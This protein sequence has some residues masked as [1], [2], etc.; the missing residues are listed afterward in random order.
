MVQ[1]AKLIGGAGTGKTTELLRI[2]SEIVSRGVDPHDIG[3]VSFTQAARTEAAERVAGEFGVDAKRLQER[4]WFRTLHSVCY[5]G[6][7]GKFGDRM[8]TGTKADREWME[9]VL[10]EPCRGFGSVGPTEDAG[11]VYEEA[12]RPAQALMIW[13]LARNRMVSIADVR[14]ELAQCGEDVPSLE[15]CVG[16]AKMYEVA[17]YRDDRM[18]FTDLAGKFAG[19][20]WDP[21]DE[22]RAGTPQGVT[23]DV[24]V[25]IFDEHQDVSRLLDSVAARLAYSPGC[26]WVYYAGDPFQSIYGFGGSD[27]RCLIDAPC[28]QYRV[29]ERSW[30]CPEAILKLG[31]KILRPSADYFDRK[32]KPNEPGGEIRRVSS[33]REIVRHVDPNERWLMIARTNYHTTKIKAFLNR[34]G[35]PWDYTRGSGGYVT[36]SLRTVCGTLY[37]L[38]KGGDVDGATW[39]TVLKNLPA[40]RGEGAFLERG[41][42]TSVVA[43]KYTPPRGW[44]GLERVTEAGGTE[45]LRDLIGSGSWVHHVQ[46]ADGYVSAIRKW[47]RSVADE[48]K[49]RVGTIHSV[50]GSEAENVIVLDSM[51]AKCNKGM[52][53]IEGRDSE[54]RIAYVA[55]TRARKRLWILSQRNDRYR[56]EF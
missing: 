54:R 34:E 28:D 8:I 44:I 13:G 9:E 11:D 2:L 29:M 12:G 4:G 45:L 38:Q 25:W 37:E 50:K 1:I 21:E 32:I 46:G 15:Y 35:L 42:K 41:V 26:R 43:G 20:V 24:P 16:V 53:T 7:G 17:K 40:G 31:E 5:Q 56:M 27:Y 23:P 48:P 33:M 30:R 10:G 22:P 36:P 52:R 49:I 51:S 19:W 6:L 55:A 3:F 39:E 18:D 14:K 47:G